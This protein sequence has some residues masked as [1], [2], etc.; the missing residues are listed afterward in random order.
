[1]VDLAAVDQ[2]D[3]I[4]IAI[5][6]M[7]VLSVR[8]LSQV[9]DGE[10]ILNVGYVAKGIDVSFLHNLRLREPMPFINAQQLAE[11]WLYLLAYGCICLLRRQ[12]EC[13]RRDAGGVSATTLAP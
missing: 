9:K 4:A 1:M 6:A 13:L 5:G 7:K 3:V 8:P 12:L 10:F 11:Q 2:A